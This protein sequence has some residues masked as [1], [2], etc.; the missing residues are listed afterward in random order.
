MTDWIESAKQ[1]GFDEAS[2]LKIETLKPMQAV[3][4]MCASDK[5]KAYGK[6]WSCPPECGT[7]EECGA[8][9]KSYRQGI[10]VQTVGKL[11]K[12]IDTRG[13]A[14]ASLRHKELFQAFTD[15]IRKEYP[16][17]LCLGAGPCSLCPDCAYP[18]PCRLPDKRIYAM[19]G[20][21]L[22]VTQVCRDNEIPYYHGPKTIAYSACVLFD[23]MQ[24]SH[25]E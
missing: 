13:Y 5:C 22:F 3:R 17:A 8:E 23:R 2:P 19:E 20:Y 25:E 16:D 14:Q 10:L 24:R 7:V 9:I 1:I 21:G 4:D 12:P 15:R 11:S 6:N 18:N